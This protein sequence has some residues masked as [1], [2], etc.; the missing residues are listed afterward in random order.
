MPALAD[1]SQELPVVCGGLSPGGGHRQL[2]II[3]VEAEIQ[4]QDPSQPRSCHD[5]RLGRSLRSRLAPARSLEPRLARSVIVSSGRL[6]SG[7]QFTLGPPFT[8]VRLSA[9]TCAAGICERAR[10]DEGQAP[11]PQLR[12]SGT[13][14]SAFGSRRRTRRLLNASSSRRSS[15]SNSSWPIRPVGEN[16]PQESRVSEFLRQVGEGV[17]DRLVGRASMRQA[18][19]RPAGAGCS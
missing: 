19:G 16:R 11:Y 9:L 2:R 1:I 8:G 17:L 5:S 12:A 14:A 7:L 10:T 18:R 13:A 6:Q 4:K 15:T 3:Q